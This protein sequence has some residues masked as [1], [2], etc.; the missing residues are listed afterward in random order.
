MR[1]DVPT[2]PRQQVVAGFDAVETN[3]VAGP[4]SVRQN[5]LEASLGYGFA[6]SDLAHLPGDATVGVEMSRQERKLFFGGA[7]AL[8][9]QANAYQIFVGWSD[10]WVDPRGR[11]SLDVTVHVSPGGIDTYNTA[12]AFNAYTQGRVTD[13]GYAYVTANFV[14]FTRLPKNWGVSNS[15]F[16]QVATRSVPDSQQI[17]L[18][19]EVLVRGYTID[20]GAFD[21]GVVS[22]NELRAPAMPLVRKSGRMTDSVAPYAFVDVGWGRDDFTKKD[23]TPVSAGVGADYQ[24]GS[25]FTANFAVARAMRDVGVTRSGDW[26]VHARIAIAY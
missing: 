6:L 23:V 26:T 22:R 24:V 13:A 18:G 17:G 16:A 9:G 3:I 25:L 12:S 19:G 4:F 14:R 8:S 1:L 11:T 5:T 2:A 10:L 21:T 7:T 15:V 20:D